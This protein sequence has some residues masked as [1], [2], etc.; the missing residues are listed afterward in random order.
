MSNDECEK[1]MG[2]LSSEVRDRRWRMIGQISRSTTQAE[3]L[4]RT[5][6]LKKRKRGRPPSTLTNT[7]IKDLKEIGQRLEPKCKDISGILH[8]IKGLDGKS[9]DKLVNAKD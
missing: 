6:V 8:T 9:F 5:S 2:K 4:L 1:V 3:E 7:V